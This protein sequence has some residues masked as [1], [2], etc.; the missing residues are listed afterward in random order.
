[1]VQELSCVRLLFPL[2]FSHNIFSCGSGLSLVPWPTL[3]WNILGERERRSFLDPRPGPPD[4]HFLFSPSPCVSF[5]L[6]LD[7]MH[8]DDWRRAGAL[9]MFRFS[10]TQ[11]H[12][13]GGLFFWIEPDPRPSVMDS[14]PH[15]LF[16]VAFSPLSLSLSCFLFHLTKE[17]NGSCERW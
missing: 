5:S 14:M 13:K 6:W 8:V 9:T 11:K 15:P 4:V 17:K 1:M 12:K 10:M 7:S 2:A 16:F 3:F